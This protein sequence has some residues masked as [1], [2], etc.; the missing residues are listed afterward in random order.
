MSNS[1]LFYIKITNNVVAEHGLSA[2]SS[3]ALEEAYEEPKN[4]EKFKNVTK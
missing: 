2:V 1:V 3:Q 4:E